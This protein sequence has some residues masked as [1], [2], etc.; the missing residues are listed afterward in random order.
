[1]EE[2]ILQAKP[3]TVVGK[4]VKR[5]RSEGWVP[6]ILY[7]SGVGSTP[8]QFDALEAER[9]VAQAGSS[10]L[11]KV[12]VEG[13]QTP[14]NAIVRDVQRHIIKRH[15]T[16]IDFQALSMTETV[17]LPIPVVLA[18][19]APAAEELGGVLIQQ[20]N[21][22]D[23][24]CLPSALVPSIEVDISGLVEIGDAISVSDLDIP[25]G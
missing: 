4:K 12:D 14:Y 21:E 24:E 18:G 1:M 17:R 8:L 22:L 16:H 11:V 10:S 2:L 19:A 7:G 9:V 15:V 23:V 25:E 20:V 13:E 3:R 5:L 6:G